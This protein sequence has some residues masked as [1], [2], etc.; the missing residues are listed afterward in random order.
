M[1]ATS[2]PP[3]DIGLRPVPND[4]FDSVC[5][6]DVLREL[7][8]HVSGVTADSADD[9]SPG[10][11]GR[12]SLQQVAQTVVQLHTAVSS[13]LS[14]RHLRQPDERFVPTCRQEGPPPQSA[15]GRT[16]SAG[17]PPGGRSRAAGQ[18]SGWCPIR[19][20]PRRVTCRARPLSST[21]RTVRSSTSSRPSPSDVLVEIP[22]ESVFDLRGRPGFFAM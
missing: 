17:R 12:L 14:V 15:C 9:L 3:F 7:R 11:D 20:V 2:C 10:T 8:R 22:K 13:G 21:L 18:R 5:R 1:D 6:V 19:T 4:L 16:Y